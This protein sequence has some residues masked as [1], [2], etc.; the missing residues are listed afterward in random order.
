[1]DLRWILPVSEYYA[2]L[3]AHILEFGLPDTLDNFRHWDEEVAQLGP[4]LGEARGRAVLDCSCGW[5]RQ[6]IALAK[7]GWQV[8]ACDVSE[9]SMAIAR[10]FAGE[11]GVSI[12]FRACDMREL[13]QE[14][15]AQF[16]WVVSCF[17]LYEI[18]SEAEICQALGEMAGVL[19]AGGACYLRLRDMDFLLE[20][21][22]RHIYHGETRVPNGRM[23]CIQ[24][25][26]FIS[27][28]E[29]VALEAFL[30]EDERLDPSDH[31]RWVT[32]TIGCRKRVTR[33]VELERWLYEAGFAQVTFM[34]QPQPWMEVQVVARKGE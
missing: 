18:A 27:A 17:A 2:R 11:E 3:N 4:V 7:L 16:D 26:D 23:I 34:P 13:T 29:V 28:D 20:E 24:D 19:K 33:K 12:D 31:F 32:E 15:T 30:R 6:T 14:F 8:T 5:G 25:W 21:Q 10:R 22:P 1:L 9:T